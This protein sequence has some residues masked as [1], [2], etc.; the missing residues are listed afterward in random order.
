MRAASA[1]A[2]TVLWRDARI[3]GTMVAARPTMSAT[4][5]T[6]TAI[7]AVTDGAPAVPS[8]AAP[9]LVISG[10]ASL[11]ITSPAAAESSARP[12]FS[13]SRTTATVPGVRPPP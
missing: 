11:P 9:G 2:V 1:S 6:S 13:A 4:A 3:A 5:S 12:T 8:I 10:A 7:D